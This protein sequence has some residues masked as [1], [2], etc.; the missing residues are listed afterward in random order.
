MSQNPINP[1]GETKLVIERA[2]RWYGAAYGLQSAILRYFNAAGA[3]LDGELGEEHSPETH[4]IPLIRRSRRRR[5][6]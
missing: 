3:D 6:I 5:A 2:L 4:V 1:Y